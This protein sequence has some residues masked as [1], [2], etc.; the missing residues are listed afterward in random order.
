LDRSPQA[1]ELLDN[2]LLETFFIES[3]EQLQKMWATTAPEDF[4]SREQAYLLL[5][6]IRKLRR[7]LNAYVEDETANRQE[8]EKIVNE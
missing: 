2:P 4:K 6:S 1:Q 7:W 3:E 8:L 5:Q